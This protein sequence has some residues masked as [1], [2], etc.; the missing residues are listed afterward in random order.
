LSF[1]VTFNAIIINNVY[2]IIWTGTSQNNNFHRNEKKVSLI[3]DDSGRS[4]DSAT[5]IKKNVPIYDYLKL[6]DPMHTN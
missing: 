4:G 6:Y 1:N 5:N 2:Y 3:Q